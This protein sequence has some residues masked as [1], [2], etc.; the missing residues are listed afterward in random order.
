MNQFDHLSIFVSMI[1]ALG[2][3]HL[4]LSAA[5]M[6]NLRHKVRIYY[7]TL[8]WMISLL[9]LQLQIW[10]VFYYRHDN[11]DW[12]FFAFLFYLYIPITVS[13]LS[14]LLIPEIKAETDL[15]EVFFHNRKWFLGLI[16]S[17]AVASLSEDFVSFGYSRPDLNFWFRIIFIFFLVIGIFIG[18]KRL[19]MPI[20]LAFLFL[21]FA[22]IA[23]IFLRLA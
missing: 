13:M 17:I 1:I 9:S 22:Y 15:Q 4:I 23:L 6:I 8:V 18:S 2:V 5:N 12:S 20:A 14:H 16:A 10:W 7:P 11:S 19:Q 21:F 3:R